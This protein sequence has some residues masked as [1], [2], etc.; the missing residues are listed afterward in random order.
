MVQNTEESKGPEK[1]GTINTALGSFNLYHLRN[2][3]NPVVNFNFHTFVLLVASVLLLILSAASVH[4][5]GVDLLFL[6]L[7]IDTLVASI[8]VKPINYYKEGYEVHSSSDLT[9]MITN[10]EL[11]PNEIKNYFIFLLIRFIIYVLLLFTPLNNFLRINFYKILGYTYGFWLLVLSVIAIL[12]IISIIMVGLG[13]IIDDYL[14]EGTSH[15]AWKGLRLE[16]SNSAL[17]LDNV[18]SRITNSQTS[19]INQQYRQRLAGAI[20]KLRNYL[21]IENQPDPNYTPEMKIKFVNAEKEF[22][23]E[24]LDNLR[25]DKCVVCYA[26]LQNA[27][28]PF[29]V[30]PICGQGGHKEHIEE[31]FVSKTIC[32]GCNSDLSA[33]NFLV[34]G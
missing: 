4:Y 29:L 27:N 15:K 31:W 12:F 32:P 26:Q 1:K 11:M 24:L 3:M 21:V 20:F 6:L 14:N 9:R 10:L 23:M 7:A 16:I 5:P 13:Y 30:C 18:I 8:I 22:S 33:S 19:V 17:E 2:D 34:L 25:K 28:G